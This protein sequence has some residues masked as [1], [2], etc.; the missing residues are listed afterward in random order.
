MFSHP[1]LQETK[2]NCVQID[3]TDPTTFQAFIS[4]C[5]TGMV[6]GLD[7]LADRLYTLSDKYQVQ[8][9]RQMCIDNLSG[10]L[11]LESAAELLAI[12][13]ERD[14]ALLKSQCIAFVSRNYKAVMQSAGW[15]DLRLKDT[16]LAGMIFDEVLEK[17][18]FDLL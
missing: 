10:R 7:A 4:Y 16:H 3:D 15:K 14:I 11:E 2:E 8:P 18:D 17:T 12:A 1:T 13:F 6:D 5:Y 9:L